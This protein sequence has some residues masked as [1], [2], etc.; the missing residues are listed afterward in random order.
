VL[1]ASHRLSTATEFQVAVRKGRRAG[2]PLVV[3]HLA[4]QYVDK[5][6]S[7]SVPVEPARIGFV[8]S[9]AVGNAVTRNRVKRRLRHLVRE[10]VAALPDGALL[11]VRAQPGAAEASYWD[12]AA[13]LDRCLDRVVGS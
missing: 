8:V 12:L 9:R 6:T 7:R 10:R 2:G 5:E 3:L 1:S 11:V 4:D 13:A